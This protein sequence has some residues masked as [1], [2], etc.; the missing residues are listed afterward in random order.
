MYVTEGTKESELEASQNRR[1]GIG[2][3]PPIRLPH[4]AALQRQKVEGEWPTN[5]VVGVTSN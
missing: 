4:Q 1:V 2:I 5:P 3:M